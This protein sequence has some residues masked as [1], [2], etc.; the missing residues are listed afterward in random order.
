MLLQPVAV[1]MFR[2]RVST[3]GAAQAAAM[4]PTAGDGGGDGQLP[5][6]DPLHPIVPLPPP[7]PPPP[8]P[9]GQDPAVGGVEQFHAD[10]SS[11]DVATCVPQCNPEHHGFELLATIDGT[12]TKFSCNVAHGLYSWMGAASEGGYIGSDAFAFLSAVL[13]HA[14]GTFVCQSFCQ[15]R[16][17]LQLI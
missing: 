1:Q 2:V 9:I 10:C 16:C 3:E 14:A 12:D 8:P 5:A 13:S 11:V 6:L 7:P 4:F 15:Q 17:P